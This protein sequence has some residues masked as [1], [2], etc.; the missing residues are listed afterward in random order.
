MWNQYIKF[1][2]STFCIINFV[3]NCGLSQDL[4]SFDDT[5]LFKINWPGKGAADLLVIY[6][7]FLSSMKISKFLLT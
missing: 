2:F 6:K 7:I 1:Y 3:V 5:I 4:Q